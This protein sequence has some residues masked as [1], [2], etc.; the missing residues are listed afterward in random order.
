MQLRFVLSESTDSYLT[1]VHGYV[2][3]FGTI[4][5]GGGSNGMH[6]RAG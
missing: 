3:A 2:L 4:I 5:P 6:R 1:A